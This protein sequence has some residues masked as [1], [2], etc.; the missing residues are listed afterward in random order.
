M[1]RT[2]L[3]LRADD[4]GV[5][6]AAS[7]VSLTMAGARPTALTDRAV[8]L[9]KT[10]RVSIAP[11][12]DFDSLDTFTLALEVTPESLRVNQVLVDSERPPVRLTLRGDGTI[13]AEVHTENGW[14]T[15][16]ST[17]RLSV[18]QVAQIRLIRT[19]RGA[20]VLELDGKAAGKLAGGAMLV[21]PG[22]KGMTI[23][24]DLAGKRGFEGTLGEVTISDAA[25][26]SAGVRKARLAIDDLR[27]RLAS[28]YG[29]GVQVI[30][31]AGAVDHRFD[32]IKAIMRAAG[33]DDL[34]QLSKLTISQKTTI[35]PNQILTASRRTVF[36]DAT[37]SFADVATEFASVF[38][39]DPAAARG[40]LD[41]AVVNRHSLDVGDVVDPVGP[42]RRAHDLP[43]MVAHDATATTPV[44][45]AARLMRAPAGSFSPALRPV[46]PSVIP[47][48]MVRADHSVLSGGLADR[49]ESLAALHPVFT[50]GEIVADL[51]RLEPHRWATY[52]PDITVGL[53]MVK[54]VPVD[55]SVIIAGR[56]DLTNQTLEIAPEVETLYIIAEEIEAR[57]GARITW[58]RPPLS[59]PDHGPD[60]GKDGHGWGTSSVV[61]KPNSKHG[62]DGG[63]GSNGDN[64]IAGRHGSDAPHLEIWAKRFI[65]M[66][67]IDVAGQDGGRGGKGQRGGHGGSGA[68]GRSG[69]WVWFFGSHCWDDPGDG[70]DGGNGG[71][72]GVGGRGGNGSDGGHITL[73]VLPETL[74]ELVTSNPFTPLVHKGDPGRGGDGGDGGLGGTGGMRGYTE[75]CDGGRRGHDGAQAQPG[76]DGVDGS[77]GNDGQIRILT[78]TEEAWNEQL[79]KP[80]LT[81]LT[82]TNAFPGTKITIRGTRFADT[83]AVVIG[84]TTLTP[85]LRADEGIDVTLPA[86]I[87]GGEHTVFLR[88]FDG[89]ESNRLV[90]GVRPHLDL[91]PATVTPDAEIALAGQAFVAGATVALS[92]ELYPANVASATALTFTMPG[93][94]GTVN[95]ERLWGLKV[96]NP[97]GRESNELTAVQP[98]VLQNG[99]TLGVHDYQFDNFTDG[100]PSWGTFEDTFGSVEVWHEL[101]DPIFGHPI[102]TGAYYSFYHY[103]LLGTANGGLAT[104][105]CTSLAA[106]ALDRFWQGQ[107]DTFATVQK[108]DIHSQLTAVHGRLLSRESLLTMHDQGRR[109]SA[110]IETSVRA[111]EAAFAS[112]GT[113]ETA[114]LLFFLPSG[115]AWDGGYFDKLADSHCVVPIKILY[116]S[117]HDGTDVAGITVQ[118]WDNNAPADTDCR[119][120]ITRNAGGELEFEFFS[121]GALKFGTADGVTL[122]TQSLAE[123]LLSDHDLPF[124]GPFGLTSF[125]ID[126]LLSPATLAVTDGAGR[127]AGH[128]GGQILSEIPGSHPAY[129]APGLFLLPSGEGL[130]R[131]ITGRSAGTYGYTSINPAGVSLNLRAVS[132]SAGEA[133]IVA[134]NG[135]GTRI[136]FVPS[137]PKTVAFSVSSEFDG[138]ARGIEIEAFDVSAMADL[139]ITATPDLSLVRISN[140]GADATLPVKLLGVTAATSATVTRDV[141]TVNLPAS[142]DLVVSVSNWSRLSAS[143]VTAAAID[144]S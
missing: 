79:T 77:P 40:V 56:L 143:D 54:T 124:S 89:E 128:F 101:L 68:R 16:D 116:P 106:T 72:G 25:I 7:N 118:V 80:W 13:R 8:R 27:G 87:G 86:A 83:D 103:F 23:G 41:A 48:I 34:S 144:A 114:P 42:A 139:D 138:Q 43:G 9:A 129:L 107:D 46:D 33:V 44:V 50:T 115:A 70:G 18:G 26:T 38:A 95:A 10:T 98:R 110:N 1:A 133:D 62:V 127:R 100:V 14:E 36:G 92:G 81:H 11:S 94:S 132:T 60:P 63:D 125:V 111:I 59:V 15:I 49:S 37:G 130:T 22:R 126:F 122:G 51:A 105:F 140:N 69:E 45:D 3:A 117:G 71:G 35:S 135:D 64:G 31:D 32:E 142:H 102:L 4:G 137:Q 39:A 29:V 93:I 67:D 112:G 104:G 5:F 109:G 17:R 24:A 55:T 21:A 123:Y 85:V 30:A 88:R 90:V 82:P 65:G 20:V 58:R 121:A 119:V 108:A 73:A 47:T 84:S 141:G 113:R 76:S 12:E 131:T 74:D 75:V 97:D 2:L 136:R 19:D 78:V 120:D 52:R 53:A 6:D 57:A 61:L 66:P 96:L 28:R 134:A 99:F 91:V